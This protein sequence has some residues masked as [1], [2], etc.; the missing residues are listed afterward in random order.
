MSALHGVVVLG[1]DTA[2][3]KTAVSAGLL[4]LAARQGLDLLPSK[5]SETGCA[6]DPPADASLLRAAALRED[7]PLALICPFPFAP[8]LA[9][10]AAAAACGAPL[11]AEALIAGVRRV[12]RAGASVLVETAGGLL[13]PYTPRFTGADLARALKLPVLLVSRNA[14]GTINQTALALAELKR[15]RLPLLGYLMVATTREETPDR[16]SNARLVAQLTGIKPLGS[17]PH[18]SRPDPD[19]LADAL[20]DAIDARRLL[21]RIT[22]PR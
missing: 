6:A 18:L 20:A 17:L 10:A 3:G 16:A 8:P 19:A 13:S 9:P 2:V 11:R 12:A 5:P 1:S 21:S 15:R 14:L 4:R 7:L 22:R